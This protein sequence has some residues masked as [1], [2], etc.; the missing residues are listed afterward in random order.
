[1]CKAVLYLIEDLR[2]NSKLGLA[3][4]AFLKTLFFNRM[5]SAFLKTPFY[6]SSYSSPLHKV[7][8]PSFE[9]SLSYGVVNGGKR[10]LMLEISA[11]RRNYINACVF[12]RQVPTQLN[13]SI[14]CGIILWFVRLSRSQSLFAGLCFCWEFFHELNLFCTDLIIVVFR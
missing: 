10:S 13:K 7:L 14:H 6:Y 2:Q 8:S 11:L 12:R 3:F 4:S 5:V 1:L 9:H